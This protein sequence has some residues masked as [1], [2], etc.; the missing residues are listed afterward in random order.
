[1]DFMMFAMIAGAVGGAIKNNG[2]DAIKNACNSFDAQQ[3]KLK[4][5]TD[6]W[7]SILGNQDKIIASARELNRTLYQNAQAYKKATIIVHDKYK[8]QEVITMVMIAVFVF[9]ILIS[10]LLRYFNVYSNIW[11]LIVNKK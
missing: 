7:K 6:Q 11:S 3:K 10:F 4:D 5:T 9:T 1:M 2:A 8:E